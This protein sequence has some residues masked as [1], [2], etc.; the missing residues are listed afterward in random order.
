MDCLGGTLIAISNLRFLT[1]SQ[2]YGQTLQEI[3]ESPNLPF[4]NHLVNLFSLRASFK[5][6]EGYNPNVK[7]LLLTLDPVVIKSRPLLL[8][9]VVQILN[10]LVEFKARRKGW[11]WEGKGE[12]WAFKET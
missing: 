9:V 11:R 6:P 1:L 12:V 7:P 10:W 4:L 8:Y 3:L 5:F 2:C